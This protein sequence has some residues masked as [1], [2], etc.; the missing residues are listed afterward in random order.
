MPEIDDIKKLCNAIAQIEANWERGDLAGAVRNA[1]ALKEKLE[2]I[3][4]FESNQE[5]TH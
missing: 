2:A 1:V 4:S 5:A 3:Y